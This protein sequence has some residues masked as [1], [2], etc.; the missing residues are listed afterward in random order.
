MVYSYGNLTLRGDPVPK[1]LLFSVRYSYIFLTI[2]F[3]EYDFLSFKDMELI[4]LSK[5]SKLILI[6][7]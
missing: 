7:K 2:H 1:K 4:V 3:K 5:F 6:Q